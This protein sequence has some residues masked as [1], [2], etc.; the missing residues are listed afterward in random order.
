MTASGEASLVALASGDT[1]ATVHARGAE[2]QSLTVAGHELLWSGDP[3]SWPARAP[4]LF[5]IVG[6]AA[7]GSV[8]V[9]GVAYPMGVHG[10]AAQSTFVCTS[11]EGDAATFTLVD[12]DETRLRY[13]FAFRLAVTHRL[14]PGRLETSLVVENR[15]AG[16]MPYAVGL[17]PGFRW[18]LVDA[19]RDAHRVVFEAA[20]RA[21]VPVI[22]P[23]G[24]FAPERRP[25]P[26]ENGRVL[27]LTNEVLAREALV[28]LDVASPRVRLEDDRGRGIT[29]TAHDLPHVALWSRDGAGFVCV[30]HWTGHG[31]PVGFTG[32]LFAKPSMRI[33]APGAAAEHRARYDVTGLVRSAPV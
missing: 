11:R 15:G 8:R 6:W 28:F 30:E 13:P 18:P 26:L 10:F 22:A 29:I 3:A 31:D 7:G 20:E 17:H 12:D 5:P 19:Q 4:I 23:G 16:P 21:S 14:A 25:V 33:L 27:A 2:L 24:L 32:D 9:D 1:R